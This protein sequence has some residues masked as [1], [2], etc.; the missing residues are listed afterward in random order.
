MQ[1]GAKC[2]DIETKADWTGNKSDFTLII[3]LEGSGAYCLDN[4]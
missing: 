4:S 1:K 3:K 2:N